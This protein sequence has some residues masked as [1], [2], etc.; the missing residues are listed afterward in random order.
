MV[1]EKS[2][3]ESE[4]GDGASDGGVNLQKRFIN[5]ADWL[6]KARA[7]SAFEHLKLLLIDCCRR[8]NVQHKCAN[9]ELAS[10]PRPKPQSERY[11]LQPRGGLNESSLSAAVTLRGDNVVQAEVSLKYA[12]SA[13]GFYRATATPDVHWKMQQLQD[14]ANAIVRALD[15]LQAGQSRYLE[16]QQNGADVRELL[17]A[18]F[19]SIKADLKLARSSLT[20]PKK[21]SLVELCNYYPIKSFIP[22]LPHDILLSFYLSSAKLVCAAYQVAQKDGVQTVTVY[23]AEYPVPR[24]VELVQLLNVA[25]AV[26]HEF[27][28]NFALLIQKN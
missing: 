27:W 13:S 19:Q 26:A 3:T 11:E 2:N 1:K 21:K 28:A 20:M 8:L 10:E 5:E 18:I 7:I 22:P 9:P 15:S 14:A 24:L 25:F 4:E 17:L 6:Q 16:F 12:K 23:Q